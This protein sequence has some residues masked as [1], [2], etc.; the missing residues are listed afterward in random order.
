MSLSERVSKLEGNR[1]AGRCPCGETDVWTGWW[2]LIRARIER[3]EGDVGG[4]EEPPRC[5]RCG[6]AVPRPTLADVRAVLDRGP[7]GPMA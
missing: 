5:A 7:G 3:N 4:H 1:T 2:P 6:G